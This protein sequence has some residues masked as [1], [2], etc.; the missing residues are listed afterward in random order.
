MNSGSP[1]SSGNRGPCASERRP[2]ATIPTMLAT[3]K[4]VKAQP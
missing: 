4:P 1:T 3:R 2:E